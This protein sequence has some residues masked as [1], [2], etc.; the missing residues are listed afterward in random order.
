[1]PSLLSSGIENPGRKIQTPTA[2][3]TLPQVLALSD[4][5]RTFPRK[6]RSAPPPPEFVE[7]HLPNNRSMTLAAV[8]LVIIIMG[9]WRHVVNPSSIMDAVRQ[10]YKSG[11]YEEVRSVVGGMDLQTN[12]DPDLA[13]Y[14]GLS[15][16]ELGQ[17]NEALTYFQT[18]V[19]LAE[20]GALAF[21]ATLQIAAIQEDLGHYAVAI[22]LVT[23]L[24]EKHSTNDELRRQAARLLDLSGRRYE[25]NRHHFALVKAGR[26][27]IDDLIF[28]ADRHEPFVGPEIEKV[29]HDPDSSEF[30]VTRALIAW[31]SGKLADSARLLRAEIAEGDNSLETHAL[32]GL[33]LL[34][35]GHMSEL[36]RWHAELPSSS[37]RHPDIWYV[38]GGWAEH[39]LRQDVALACYL[40]AVRLDAGFQQ[41][42]FRLTI[43]G[44][45]FISDEARTRL[46][47]RSKSLEQYRLVCKTIF[48]RGPENSL[49]TS[50]IDLAESL[51][52]LHEAIGWC[53]I[54]RS[55]Q[56][57]LINE[58]DRIQQLQ[59]RVQ[60]TDNHDEQ[61]Q[62]NLTK[63]LP[64]PDA[65]I[66]EWP[67]PQAPDVFHASTLLAARFE[68]E[69][70]TQGL[71]FKYEN[72]A[73][74]L[75][76]LMIHQSMGGGVAV[77]DFDKDTWPDVFF[78]QGES[79]AG[80]LND[81]LFR[82]RS[83]DSFSR[84]DQLSEC[85]SGDY[86]HGAAIGDLNDDGFSDIYVANKGPN[87][88]YVNN[89][90]G[91]F[92]SAVDQFPTPAW[93]VSCAIADLT[94][95]SFPELLD[96]NY[97][98]WGKPFTEVCI[99]SELK[100]PRTCPPDRFNGERNQL[101]LNSADGSFRNVSKD[102]GLGEALGK[103]LGVIAADFHG[104]GHLG[105]FV[106]NDQVPNEYFQRDQL[107]SG[108]AGGLPHFS[109]HA[110]VAGL[111][112]NGSG[113]A[114][115]CMGVA[116]A[117][118]NHD[119]YL[120]MFVTNFYRQ[121][122]TLYVSMDNG[123][124][125][126]VTRQSG[127]FEPGLLKLGFG[128]QFLDA[129]LDGE[130]DLIV[131]NGH[132]DDFSHKDIPYA[133]QPQMFLNAG[134]MQFTES[135]AESVGF[136]FEGKHIA[137]G[138]ATLDWNRDGLD[139]F[140]VSHIGEPADLV[141][142]RTA[143]HGHFLSVRLVGNSSA[144]DAIGTTVKLITRHFT[145]WKHLTAG[146]G[147]ASSNQKELRFG[148]GNDTVAQTIRVQWPSGKIQEFHAVEADREYIVME[149]IDQ[150]FDVPR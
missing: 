98:E 140:A 18:I 38:R 37:D 33:V 144:R 122:N 9:I 92:S 10:A 35:Q 125:Q 77:L 60:A 101:F 105:F 134:E 63:D 42:V 119:G 84:V 87:R 59:T 88:L 69:A 110:Y 93:T 83:G 61:S 76:G 109:D 12:P 85:G 75:S 30:R 36:A 136:Y 108:P 15:C 13:W 135:T 121:P 133:M 148:L 132:L 43:V 45:D 66:P 48:F 107:Q 131:G 102:V 27:S 25:A 64:I 24:L 17:Q 28:L 56:R 1:M 51:E 149:S 137:R 54:R 89:G 127:L 6:S 95:D 20:D 103:G 22:D 5:A 143:K 70:V 94:G 115:A 73:N 47:S 29:L 142:N 126:D 141:T 146:D 104:T 71:N 91:T 113:E 86:S 46:Q 58:D 32:L 65:V 11:N 124:F 114:L 2:Q 55:A 31:R 4:M 90:D 120:D 72:G 67:M 52:R 19:K 100:L 34:D 74:E 23:S 3:L 97:L 50:A 7:V 106:A 112:F 40:K 26:H 99:D 44:A 81:G 82:N 16:R 123:G 49:V 21:D 139:D 145:R 39:L 8:I 116:S 138:V 41:A 118:V 14:A 78:P 53:G 111:A 57:G 128:T 62:W 117:D 68:S 150:L 79:S 80:P 147:Y 130:P 129:N 96:V